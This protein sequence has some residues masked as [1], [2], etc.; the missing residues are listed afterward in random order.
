MREIR[1]RIKSV[2]STQ[3]I[4]K[5]MK[6]VSAAKLRR[7]QKSGE[8]M[9]AFSEQCREI[10]GSL[11]AGSNTD[12]P[13][14]TPRQESRAVTY[15]LFVG[16]RGL[17]GNYNT[18][19]VRYMQELLEEKTDKTA[20]V[21]VVGRWG[22]DV[23][24]SAGLPIRETYSDAGD[25]PVMEEAVSLSERLKRTYLD[26][27][28]D[29]VYLVYQRYVSAL[30]QVPAAVRLLPAA[31]PQE[32]SAAEREYIFEPS[33]EAV[34]DSAVQLFVN[35]EVF[36]ALQEARMAE[37]AAR[38]TAMTAATDATDELISQLNLDLN[39]ARQA[40]ITTEISEIVGGANALKKK[41]S[42]SSQ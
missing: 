10:L 32:K 15:V 29:E 28:A 24:A 33:R 2:K 5:A 27:A 25:V 6:M 12:H 26:G 22:R 23:L 21:I 16:N 19:L 8:D 11:L 37:Q 13:L 31:P 34:L 1:S 4:T 40:A 30:Q 41:D 42:Q 14:L 20:S 36:S 38:M 17:C 18:A 7:A 9:R 3:Q 39:R 35:C